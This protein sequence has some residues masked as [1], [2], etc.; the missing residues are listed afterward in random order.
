MK[1][2]ESVA[3]LADELRREV[4]RQ[5]QERGA[6]LVPPKDEANE[7]D[8]GAGNRGGNEPRGGNAP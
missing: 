1:R 6:T 8:G 4:E 2:Q 7:D 5:M 3:A